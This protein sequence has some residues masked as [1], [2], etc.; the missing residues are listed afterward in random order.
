MQII[1]QRAQPAT[2]ASLGVIHLIDH[3]EPR[4]I[5]F[6]G[7]FPNPLRHRLNAVLRI[8]HHACGLDR[9]Q[10]GPRFVREHMKSRG[11]DEVDLDALPFGERHGVGH[12]CPAGNFFFVIGGHRRAVIHATLGR[13]HLC[14]MQQRG[15]Q[16]RLSAMC[17][18]HYSYVADLTSLVR[19]HSNS[20]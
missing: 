12:G 10:R 1:D 20:P 16:R 5:G 3:Y 6:L 15:N 2:P 11:V 13:S 17:M 7:V 8:H 4:N 9:Q 18:P 14:G 19:F